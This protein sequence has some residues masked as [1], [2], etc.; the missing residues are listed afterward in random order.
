MAEYRLLL[1][2]HRGSPVFLVVLLFMADG[3]LPLRLKID[4][5]Y[6]IYFL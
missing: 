1:Y 3:A 4:A 6:G 2:N 5:V